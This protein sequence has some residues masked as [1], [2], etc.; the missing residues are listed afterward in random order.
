V[1]FEKQ[2]HACKLSFGKFASITAGNAELEA[3]SKRLNGFLSEYEAAGNSFYMGMNFLA[4]ST[5][6]A[7][8]LTEWAIQVHGGYGYCGEY[9]VEQLCRDVKITS[10]YEGTNGIQANDVI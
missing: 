7:F 6:I 5:D 1:T 4:Y 8:R 9:P 2:L 10:I 3:T